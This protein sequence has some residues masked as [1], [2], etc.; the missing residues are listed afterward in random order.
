MKRDRPAAAAA[1]VVAVAMVAAVMVVVA[2]AADT[3]AEVTVVDAVTAASAEAIK[4]SSSRD[5]KF[6]E[7]VTQVT[8]F[9]FSESRLRYDSVPCKA[10]NSCREPNYM[11][12][13][14]YG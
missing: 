9:L 3:V 13:F 1:V 6:R 12:V 5:S 10:R 7:A 11:E 4:R 2:A 8:A 14:F